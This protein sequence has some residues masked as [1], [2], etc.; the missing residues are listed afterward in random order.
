MFTEMKQLIQQAIQ[1]FGQGDLAD[2]SRHLLT[3][4]GYA[5][6]RQLDVDPVPDEFLAAVDSQGNFRRDRARVGEW[7]SV[8]LLY[9][10]TDEEIRRSQ[11]GL[12][13][14]SRGKVVDN[15]IIESYLFIALDLKRDSYSRTE[16]AQITREVNRLF[17]MPVM[18]LFRH[19]KTLTLA[20]I[21]RRLHKREPNKDVL[22]KVTLIKDIRVVDPHRA[23][24]E[25]L[26]NLS[27]DE[28]YQRHRCTNFVELHRAWQHILDTS[29]LNKSFYRE[30]AL[31]FQK[32]VGGIREI[33]SQT[34]AE[35]GVLK[36]P[37]TNDD[38]LKREFAV[39]L[40]GR[41]LFCWFLTKKS[42]QQGIPL[43]PD[44]ILS[45]RIA[46]QKHETSYYHTILEPLFFETLNKPTDKRLP[47]FLQSPWSHVPF[48][49]GGLF[50]PHIDDYYE[51]N[52]GYSRHL[53]TLVVPDGWC[54]EILAVFEKYHFTIEENTPID[55]QVAID[56][57]MLGQ[58]FE[59]LLAEI[60]PE[61]GETARKSTGSFYTPRLIVDYMVS[62]SLKA[63][64]H[65]QTGID[66]TRLS[67]LL[68]YTDKD[69]ELSA[70]EQETVLDA[71]ERLKILDPACGSG[72]FPLGIVQKILLVLQKID[73]HAKKWFTKLLQSIP[74][75]VARQVVQKK[76]GNERTLWDYT[77]KF[78]LIRN[79]IH[80][81]DIQPVA[82]EIS[83][84][85]CFLSLV[86][87]EKVND[88]EENRGIMALPNLE[89][90]FVCAN[91]LVS[92]P[93]IADRASQKMQ[94]QRQLFESTDL[95]G[96]L[97]RIL[98]SYFSSYG[99]EKIKLQKKF[100]DLQKQLW[101]QALEWMDTGSETA[102]L[103]DW[104]P[105]GR[106]PAPFFHPQWMF[107]L[108]EKFDLV[109]GNPPYM[110]VQGVQQTQ[111]DY[112]PY[113]RDKYQSAR[114][115]FDL[116]A[117]FIERGY[118]LLN[119][120]GE[121]A[122]IVPHKFFQA[123]FGQSLRELLTQRSALRQIVRFGSEQ[124]FNEATTYTC[125]LFL[126]AQP[127]QEFD[128]LEVRTLARGDEVFQAARTR[129]R[130][131]DYDFDQLPA[132]QMPTNGQP[133]EWNFVIGKEG[134]ILRR[135]QQHPKTLN[136]VIQKIF[137]GLQTSA[138]KIFV[139]EVR[140]ERPDTLL[141][142]S[143]HSEG[144][145]EIERGLV[146]PFLMG[147]D[148][149][150]YEPAIAQNVVIFPY[151]IQSDK[152]EL[153]SQTFIQEHFPLGW[154]YLVQNQNELASRERGRFANQWYAFSRPQNMVEFQNIKIMTPDISGKPEMSI[155]LKGDLY[156]TTTIY[157]FV[158]NPNAQVKTKF[159]LGVLNS[160]VMWF[161][162]STT[163]NVLRGN[164]LRF[165]TN[166]LRPFPLAES[167]LAQEAV[168]ER[169]V[170]Y[171]LYLKAQSEPYDKKMAAHRRVM[172]AYFEQLIDAV[173]YEIY[174]PEELADANKQ[175]SHL[176]C[177]AHLPSLDEMSGDKVTLL[178]DLFERL[179]APS[180]P[181]RSLIHFLDGIETIRIIEEKSNRV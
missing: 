16:L 158:F 80:G 78:G 64:L 153:M 89:F 53:N 177:S 33:G 86:V 74:D 71:L 34:I 31:Q 82:V 161:F 3:V 92:L 37:S 8:H 171:V 46:G 169:L 152:A 1:R 172:T 43:I 51:P 63:Y 150:R 179:Y 32:L 145:V 148:V 36:L 56:P 146:K 11:Q 157:S 139:L 156:H 117:L 75:P 6:E 88:L 96:D 66:E 55:V 24:V 111:G 128:L 85:R 101:D 97:G 120:Q 102:M 68:A 134:R 132:P 164:Y 38:I 138:D 76:L 79:T 12:L 131:P 178:C 112:V 107:G 166:Y 44:D 115:S 87:E 61:T 19:G 60:N 84:L 35:P 99:E 28:L 54:A 135:I 163:G 144:E 106:T 70:A 20:V 69:P 57:E 18:V 173:V 116:Y 50:E 129:A 49:N 100:Y 149:H 47:Q 130:H 133:V 113:Y 90:K 7:Q 165:K 175:P 93:E 77:R 114:G 27:L 58:I 103:A 67:T 168:I 5:S 127:Q 30:V 105:F 39:R 83:K 40:I 104:D 25:I 121:F 94:T 21:S 52:N 41:L 108:K 142:Y 124:V 110:R 141:C 81:V 98:E 73:P 154:R 159:M 180:H 170:E 10:I 45:S 162:V 2:N 136:D 13:F 123:A 62:E 176:L 95:L 125:L 126:S 147:K 15:S 42:S 48:L 4:L 137:V 65:T 72:A 91:T 167:S 155:D 122:Y 59:N 118:E 119:K 140:E 22:E 14:E 174:F 160:K 17:A 151:T 143:R 109:I 26:F 23:H 9:Q 29:E 181:V